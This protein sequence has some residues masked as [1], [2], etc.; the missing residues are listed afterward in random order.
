MDTMMKEGEEKF[1]CTM[2]EWKNT[3]LVVVS[4][5]NKTEQNIKLPKSIK[6]VTS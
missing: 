2:L 5:A 3:A 1:D 6:K 4:G